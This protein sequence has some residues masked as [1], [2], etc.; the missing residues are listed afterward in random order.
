MHNLKNTPYAFRQI[1]VTIAPLGGIS[2]FAR[3]D[4]P[5]AAFLPEVAFSKPHIQ[6]NTRIFRSGIRASSAARILVSRDGISARL[7]CF[8]FAAT[9]CKKRLSGGSFT[10]SSSIASS[11]SICIDGTCWPCSSITA[12]FTHM[13]ANSYS[14]SSVMPQSSSWNNARVIGNTP[15]PCQFR[16][17]NATSENMYRVQAPTTN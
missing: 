11:S 15:Q 8:L 5:V 13:A 3:G 4:G 6:V 1:A 16:L 17:Q 2:N 12:S 10:T 9:N 7:N 14:F